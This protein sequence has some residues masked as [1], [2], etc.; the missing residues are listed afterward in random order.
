M[1]D[2]NRQ[3]ASWKG[4]RKAFSQGLLRLF[5]E[6]NSCGTEKS[7]KANRAFCKNEVKHSKSLFFA[8]DE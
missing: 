7:S 4:I 6:E 2:K 1:L 5:K 3:R 8:E